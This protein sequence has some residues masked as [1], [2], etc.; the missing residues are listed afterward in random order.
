M[1][2]SGE[3]QLEAAPELWGVENFKTVIASCLAAS[4]GAHAEEGVVEVEPLPVDFS[5]GVAAAVE[6]HQVFAI[7]EG[8]GGSEAAA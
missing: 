4:A 8:V 3:F 2:Y 1:E 6:S 7:I 5:G